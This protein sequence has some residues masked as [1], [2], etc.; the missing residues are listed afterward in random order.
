MTVQKE[1]SNRL[2]ADHVT[3]TFETNQEP[4]DTKHADVMCALNEIITQLKKINLY[5]EIGTTTEL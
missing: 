1:F 5:F 2:P 3:N 4:L